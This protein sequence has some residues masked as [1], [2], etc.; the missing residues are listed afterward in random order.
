[1]RGGSSR[2]AR[3]GRG[4]GG[5]INRFGKSGQ[6]SVS[7]VDEAFRIDT[8]RQLIQFRDSLQDTLEFPS[9]LTSEQR[10]IIH[11]EGT[12]L[13]LVTKS[14]GSKKKEGDRQLTVYRTDQSARVGSSSPGMSLT[15]VISGDIEGEGLEGGR[16]S[17][18]GLGSLRTPLLKLLPCTQSM[19]DTAA[20][21]AAAILPGGKK[22]GFGV[23]EMIEGLY[24]WESGARGLSPRPQ[25]RQ[26]RSLIECVAA[27]SR[28]PPQPKVAVTR[29]RQRA[30]AEAHENWSEVQAVRR[31]LPA[32]NRRSDFLAALGSSQVTIVSGDTGCGKS[33]QIPQ[34]ILEN[35]PAANIIVTQPRRVAAM[36]LA[37]RVAWEVCHPL[38]DLVG[39]N[40]RL[41][42]AL[43]PA[44]RL[45]YVTTGVLLRKL[46][47]GGDDRRGGGGAGTGGA[48]NPPP[49]T[50]PSKL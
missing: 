22:S 38:G 3:G 47:S 24:N 27:M 39:Y 19:L 50:K 46:L 33:T 29:D 10:A 2:G 12:K 40:V 37:E 11:S 25:T 18:D 9:T 32:A 1:M 45:L 41:E 5:S 31:S 4:G 30:S 44:T 14:T 21:L 36:S 15:G 49:E 6:G 42:S 26:Q 20:R 16:D 35:E 8:Q 48:G 13:G 23:P 34:Y 17:V 43:S 28:C 7:T